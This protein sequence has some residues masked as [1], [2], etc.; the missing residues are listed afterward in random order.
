MCVLAIALSVASVPTANYSLASSLYA[1]LPIVLTIVHFD[2][3]SI[4]SLHTTYV[5]YYC[6]QGRADQIPKMGEITQ[7]R[8]RKEESSERNSRKHMR[9]RKCIR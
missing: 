7:L 1:D 5:N 4:L 2:G 6:D 9:S 3:T 8:K